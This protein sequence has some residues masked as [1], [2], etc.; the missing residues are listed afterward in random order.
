MTNKKLTDILPRVPVKS[1][2]GLREVDIK[3]LSFDSR[4]TTEGTAFFAIRGTQNDGHHYIEQCISK[5]CKVI[6]CEEIPE[7]I[8]EDVVFIKVENTAFALAMAAANFFEHP[9]K[10][11]KL[12]G[13]TG[14]NGKTTVATLL[15]QLFENNGYPTGLISTICNKIGEQ[16]IPSTH[17][18]PDPIRLNALLRRMVDFGCSHAF[19]EVSSHAMSQM[20]TFGLYFAGGIF[21]NLTHDHLDY[22]GSFA[23]YRDAK[24]LFFDLLP[25]DAFALVNHDDRNSNFMLQNTAALKKT[26]SISGSADFQVKVIENHFEGLLLSVE[27]KEIFTHLIG[28]F[29]ASNLAAILGASILLGFSKEEAMIGLSKLQSAEGR[30]EYIKNDQHIIGI[31][32]YAHTPDAIENVLKTINDIRTRN[33]KLI[34]VAGAGGDRDKTKRP[35]MARIASRLSDLLIITSDNPR[36]EDPVEIIND[37][38]KGVSAEHYKKTLAIADRRE[39][40]HTAVAMATPGDIILVAGKGHEKYQ[41]I[42]GVKYPF[43]DKKELFERLLNQNKA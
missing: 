24:K 6:F 39:A 17:T 26:Y 23:A 13:V 10:Q 27:S 20:R 5:G 33:E 28:S 14:T 16:T 18:T 43:D 31:V 3:Q 38:R 19:M 8:P 30:F 32:D 29:N 25:K 1:I 41:E 4:N 15:H 22:H 21:T 9:S 34:T 12:V 2:S 35:E 11:L 37:M 36:N 40:I 7:E 42:K